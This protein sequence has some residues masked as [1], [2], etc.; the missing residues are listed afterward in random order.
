LT[1]IRGSVGKHPPLSGTKAPELFCFPEIRI[2]R[3]QSARR[4]RAR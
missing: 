3:L 2:D 4:T 1:I